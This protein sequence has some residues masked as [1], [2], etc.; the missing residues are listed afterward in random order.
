MHSRILFSSRLEREYS[1]L[2]HVTLRSP[3]SIK[4]MSERQINP[5]TC[6]ATG[7]CGQGY[8]G[9]LRFSVARML[10]SRKIRKSY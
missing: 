2:P 4:D 5:I 8:C 9:Y 10:I 7:A 3:A 1:E 6:L